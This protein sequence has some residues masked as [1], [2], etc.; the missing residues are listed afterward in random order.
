[1]IGRGGGIAQNRCE[2]GQIN[3][4][5]L[6]GIPYYKFLGIKFKKILFKKMSPVV[7][8]GRGG[9]EGQGRKGTCSAGYAQ[10]LSTHQ[11][12]S[13]LLLYVFRLESAWRNESQG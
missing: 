5:E 13:K 7:H 2:V 10:F 11:S 4:I 12:K 9:G 8:N 1:M 6:R 3:D